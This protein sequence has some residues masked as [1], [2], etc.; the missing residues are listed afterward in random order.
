MAVAGSLIYDTEIDKKG[1]NKDLNSITDSVKS[2]GTKI[3]N[4]VSALGITK[5]IETTINTINN[6]IDGAVSRIDTLNNF[7]KVMDNLGVASQ[8]SEKAVN[9]LNEGLQGIPT[10]L[11]A[12]SLSVQRFTSV[13]GDVNK[14][15]EYFL[16]LNNAILAGGAS[17]EIQASAV[18]QLSQAYSRGKMEMEEWR[19]L[20]TAIPAQLK[21]IAQSMNMTT[22]ELGTGLREG[23]ISMDTFMEAMVRLNKEGT[24]QFLSFE[25][26][27][28]NATGGIKTS[29]TNAKT[30]ITRGVANII[31]TIDKALKKT[32][33]KGLGN[34]ISNIGSTAEKVLK[35]VADKISKIDF[36]KI[37]NTM[38]QLS[39]VYGPKI[40]SVFSGLLGVFKDIWTWATKNV[41]TI[42]S[43]ISVVISLIATMKIYQGVMTVIKGI[44]LAKNI[45]SCLNPMASLVALATGGVAVFVTLSK[46]IANETNVLK[47]NKRRG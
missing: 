18:E 36:S 28:K 14:S 8:D 38:K 37:L 2:G 12:A 40:K 7:P 31:D 43:I 41:S 44:D 15:T 24:G 26:Q 35:K 3:K 25:K 32:E 5:I 11:D 23:K 4:I 6:S 17:Q 19:T 10:T 22:D 16:A 1:F 20:Q 9:R 34:I 45:I 46:A 39:N 42:T 21:Q 30:A 29:I 27:A 13:N 47:R 33:L